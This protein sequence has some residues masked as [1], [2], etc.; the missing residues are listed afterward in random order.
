[1]LDRRV[2]VVA[3]MLLT[4]L[5][6]A[7]SDDD[8]TAPGDAVQTV[9]SPTFTP[10][11]G[12]YSSVQTV[13]VGCPTADAN[14]YY[15]LDGSDPTEAA[16]LYDPLS[17]GIVVSASTTIKARAYKNG[18]HASAVATGQYSIDLTDVATPGFNPRG[19]AYN[20]IQNVEITCATSNA[21]IYYT[22][23]GNDPDESS[24]LYTAPNTITVAATT[25]IKAR[26]YMDGMDP[27]VIATA[28]YTIDLPDVAEP[29][30]SPPGGVYATAQMVTITCATP[31]AQIRYT[32]DG[33]TPDQGSPL[34]RGS[35]SVPAT[36]TVRARA[37]ATDMDPSPIA[38]ETLVIIG[39]L[40]AYYPFNGTA[41]D[42][43]GN[44]HDGTPYGV[45]SATDRHGYGRS[46]YQFDGVDDY[47][48][49]PDEASFDF[50]E[51][52]I[53]VWVRVD[54]LPVV[55]GPMQPGRYTTINKGSNLGNYTLDV[56]KYGGASYC[57]LS[58]SHRTAT[59]NWGMSCTAENLYRFTWYQVTV[60]MDTEINIYV[61][62]ALACTSTSMTTAVQNDDNVLIGKLRSVTDERPFKGFIDDVRFYNRA[63]SATE[64]QQIYN[65][66]N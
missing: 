28:D 24:T 46:A 38:E 60:T 30:I 41:N 4:L 65:A 17:A 55:P 7:C 47:V 43:S 51:Y 27:S 58:Y 44:N 48:E 18:M 6:T 11:A 20:D 19:G 35:F 10:P 23:D 26:A 53:S 32:T 56:A 14:I 40:V 34:Y 49:L 3:V 39:G 62:G 61:N 12:N 29:Q 2:L 21:N 54:T 16:T 50:T 63:L 59:G 9:G 8:T 64:I 45:L 5:F 25:T 36:T 13:T 37:Y 66:E 1:M 52:T 22:L 33:T 42:A 57:N 31:G 15:T